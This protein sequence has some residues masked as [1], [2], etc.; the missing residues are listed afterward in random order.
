MPSAIMPGAEP[1]SAA[2]GP[3]GALLVHGFCGSPFSMRRTAER[4]ADRGL[5]VEAPLLPGHGTAIEDLVPLGWSDWSSAVEEVYLGLRARC[6][7]VAVVGHSMGGTLACWLA[8]RHP[9]LRG[10]AVV[11][12]LVQPFD[13]ELRAGARMLLEGGIAI[14]KGEPPDTADPTASFPTYDGTPLAAF[15]SL[16][17]GVEEVASGLDRITCPVL[18]ISSRKDHVVPPANGDLL[19]SSA[20]GP[21]ERV[22]IERSYHN[23]MV[24]F[25]HEEVERRIEAFVVSV[26]SEPGEEET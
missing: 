14:W 15:V 17:E 21:S 8:E 1:F 16:D 2:G 7:R 9:C 24:D 23:A 13:G 5:T 22:W 19:V 6:S 4:L 20:G 25:D 10:I 12:P 26:T 3:V 18:C 11:N